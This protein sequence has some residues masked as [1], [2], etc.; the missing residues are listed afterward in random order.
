MSIGLLTLL[1]I[2]FMFGLPAFACFRGVD[3]FDALGAWLG[4]ILGI[5]IVGS[6]V[7]LIVHFWKV[8]I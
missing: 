4:L 8:Q 5:V 3:Y 6:V 2:V 7:V 1:G